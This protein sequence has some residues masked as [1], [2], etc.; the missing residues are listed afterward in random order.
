[1]KNGKL[2]FAMIVISVV[3]SLTACS[4]PL[5]DS[6]VKKEVEAELVELL[7]DDETIESIEI[8]KRDTQ[9]ETKDTTIYMEVCSNNGKMAYVRYY[10]ASYYL[11]TNE[12]WILDVVYQCDV[13]RWTV[14]PLKGVD[15]KEIIASIKDESVIANGEEWYIEVGNIKNIAID[16]QETNLDER[17]DTVVITLTLNDK[18]QE[19]KGQLKINYTFDETWKLD[20]ISGND[21]FVA[22]TKPGFALEITSE[23]LIDELT[24]KE[25]LLSGGTTY[26][27]T[28]SIN[29]AEISNFI[30]N[31]EISGAKGTTQRYE[32]SCTLTKSH[33]MFNLN[34]VIPYFYKESS[35][36]LI[37]PMTITPELVSI[38]IVGDWNGTYIGAG[39]SGSATLSITECSDNGKIIGVYSY[40]P[41]K[42]DRYR[43]AGSYQVL[44]T[45]D[46][47][48]LFMN[49]TAGDWINKDSSAMSITK[50]DITAILYI[51]D[52]KINGLGQ[53]GVPF[54]VER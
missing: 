44:G 5:D 50:K 34:M 9:K 1:M 35:G 38:D 4:K 7:A 16:M 26:E 28:I 19:A 43:Q 29:E 31:K 27:Q 32:C 39:D 30:I 37:Q 24:K 23:D 46:M 17:K 45:I 12:E 21:S 51:E 42:I 48:T 14:A 52:S 8:I 53:K 2:L 33:A 20:Y 41:S 6:T 22:T 49:L 47:T 54:I 15:E 25:V 18:V 36:W 40:T 10:T 13:D 11:S 3:L